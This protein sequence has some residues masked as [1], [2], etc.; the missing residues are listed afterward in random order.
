MPT[1]D[2]FNNDAFSLVNMTKAINDAPYQPGRIG[3]LGW[4]SEEGINTT[5]LSIEQEGTSLSLV[6]AGTRGQSGQIVT[7]DKRKL[8]PI[9]T[10]HLPQQD[11]I[12]ADVVYGVRA[13]GTES[14]VQAMQGVVLVEDI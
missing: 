6:P 3:D 13:F 10:V 5:V 11:T 4:F 7:S 2:I 9:S 1:L 8:I 12:L 14:E